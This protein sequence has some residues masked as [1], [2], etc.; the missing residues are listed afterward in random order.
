M[1]KEGYQLCIRTVCG[2]LEAQAFKFSDFMGESRPKHRPCH[3]IASHPIYNLDCLCYAV[4]CI[5]GHLL[6][7]SS[8][9]HSDKEMYP[10]TGIAMLYIKDVVFF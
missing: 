7:P 1:V 4:A 6:F 9:G 2:Y 5:L 3:A 10:R 8:V